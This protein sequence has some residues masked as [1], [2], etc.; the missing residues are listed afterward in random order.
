WLEFFSKMQGPRLGGIAVGPRPPLRR[1]PHGRTGSAYARVGATPAGF[2]CRRCAA[3][4]R[5]DAGER[6]RR[7]PH[8]VPRRVQPGSVVTAAPGRCRAI[9]LED[10]LQYSQLPWKIDVLLLFGPVIFLEDLL[11]Y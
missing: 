3:R 9:F 6:P 1:R 11:Q 4:R 5:S 8:R 2:P 10:L 7:A